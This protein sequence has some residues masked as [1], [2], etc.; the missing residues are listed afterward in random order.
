MFAEEHGLEP[1][2]YTLASLYP[3]LSIAV[4]S[5]LVLGAGSAL[6]TLVS[7]VAAVRR[8]ITLALFIAVAS[9]LMSHANLTRLRVTS[10]VPTQRIA[11]RLLVL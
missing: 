7:L 1:T 4:N 8:A 6:T 9:S 10:S 11:P 2:R 5:L 3:V